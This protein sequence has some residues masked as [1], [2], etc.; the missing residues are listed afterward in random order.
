MTLVFDPC[1]VFC[2]ERVAKIFFDSVSS[3]R[4]CCLSCTKPHLH[5]VS[6]K[7]QMV[8]NYRRPLAQMH[9]TWLYTVTILAH[10]LRAVVFFISHLSRSLADRWGT[11]IDFTTS[12]L[13]SSRF[14]AFRSMI[15]HSRPVQS[16][17]LSL[18]RVLCLPLR[19][20][21]CT[22]PCRIVLSSSHVHENLK[23]LHFI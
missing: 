12:L 22:V 15:F 23:S 5:Y 1:K 10:T 19:L 20:P 13:H 6:H 4:V 17:M 16:L 18:H 8:S 21:P 9:L 7:H 2:A 11:A 3:V 14:W